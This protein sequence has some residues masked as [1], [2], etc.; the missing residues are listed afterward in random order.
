MSSTDQFWE[1]AKEA[2]LL[3][4]S[5]K[6]GDDRESLLELAR[7]WTRA[8]ISERQLPDTPSESPPQ[9]LNIMQAGS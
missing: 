8:A 2:F 9:T 3:A 5:A 7:T 1:Y 4:S 6:S